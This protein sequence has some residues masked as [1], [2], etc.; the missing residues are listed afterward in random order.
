MVEQRPKHRL[1]WFQFSRRNLM[2]LM[3]VAAG[4]LVTWRLLIGPYRVQEEAMS[5]LKELEH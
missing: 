3:T 4:L 1:R 2:A 5:A